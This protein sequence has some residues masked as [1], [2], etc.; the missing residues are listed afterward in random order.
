MRV[1]STNHHSSEVA[2]RSLES[3]WRHAAESLSVQTWSTPTGDSLQGG[4]VGHT[5]AGRCYFAART[6]F[7]AF[8]Q[9]RATQRQHHPRQQHGAQKK[10]KAE[11]LNRHGCWTWVACTYIRTEHMYISILYIYIYIYTYTIYIYLYYINIQLLI[12][13]HLLKYINEIYPYNCVYIYVYNR[14]YTHSIK[15][16]MHHIIIS[17]VLEVRVIHRCLNR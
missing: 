6:V 17:H 14:I 3:K 15:H 4:T 9:I 8:L 11:G 12:Y 7:A 16:V 13:I 10:N 5:T 1:T 2:V